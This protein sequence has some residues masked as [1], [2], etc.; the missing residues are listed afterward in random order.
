MNQKTLAELMANA[1]L[2]DAY[3]VSWQTRIRNTLAS[4]ISESEINSWADGTQLDGVALETF[5][6]ADTAG[7][8]LDWM[9]AHS[10]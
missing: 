8:R 6:T 4:G 5:L 3:L 7:K 9:I 2:F 1:E 10:R